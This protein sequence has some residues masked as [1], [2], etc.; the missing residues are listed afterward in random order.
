ML[1]HGLLTACCCCRYLPSVDGSGYF[2]VRDLSHL[3][4]RWIRVHVTKGDM[5]VIPAGIHHRGVSTDVG[6][7]LT[8]LPATVLFHDAAV[9]LLSVAAVSPTLAPQ[10]EHLIRA[11]YLE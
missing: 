1:T 11:E 10:D 2:D 5:I 4:D 6:N 8:A 9:G 7:N 3:T